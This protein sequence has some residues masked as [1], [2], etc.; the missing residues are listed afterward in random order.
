VFHKI[1]TKKT[2]TQNNIEDTFK[3]INRN[4]FSICVD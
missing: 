3:S 1:K 2:N 4:R